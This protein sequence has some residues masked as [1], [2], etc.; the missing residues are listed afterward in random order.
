[1]LSICMSTVLKMFCLS[2]SQHALVEAPTQPALVE[3]VTQDAFVE[4]GLP[5]TANQGEATNHK[6]ASME[7]WT[8]FS[9][10]RKPTRFYYCGCSD[11]LHGL[12]GGH[13]HFS[14]AVIFKK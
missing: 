13:F 1:M 12:G 14:C 7:E 8:H 6:T 5:L 10:C 2:P 11:H 3:V 4:K 9:Y